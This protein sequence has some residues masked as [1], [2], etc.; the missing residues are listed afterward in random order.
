MR[1]FISI[2]PNYDFEKMYILSE[3]VLKT[4]LWDENIYPCDW[5]YSN[6]L[7]TDARAIRGI[8]RIN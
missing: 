1:N 5:L 8:G 2:T 7:S 6:F 3:L 4:K